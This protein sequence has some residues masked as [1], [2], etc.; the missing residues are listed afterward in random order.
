[1]AFQTKVADP[2]GDATR[3]RASDAEVSAQLS[4]SDLSL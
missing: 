4:A 2:L 3:E 1:M